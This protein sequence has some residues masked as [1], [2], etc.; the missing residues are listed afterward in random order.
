MGEMEILRVMLDKALAELSDLRA[1]EAIKQLKYR[2][3]R[4]MDTADMSLLQSVLAPDF[5]F[6]L[7]GSAWA[8]AG[9]SAEDFVAKMTLNFNSDMGTQHHGHH[10]EIKI[11]P[12]G[13]SATGIWYLQDIVNDTFAGTLMFGTNF[14]HDTYVRTEDGWKIAS[15]RWT[16][17]IEVRHDIP[18]SVQYNDRYLADHGYQIKR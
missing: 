17:H 12:D 8:M 11:T 6:D 3:F 13:L 5:S 15:S 1:V 10:P 7:R 4:S 16:R 14:Y 18:W 9:E 2:Y